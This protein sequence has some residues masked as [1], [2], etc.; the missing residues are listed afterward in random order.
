MIDLDGTA[1]KKRL[2]AN[3]IL[4]VSLAVAKAA[5]EATG[6]PLYRTSAAPTRA[7]CRCPCMNMINGGAHADNNLDLQEFMLVPYGFST[8]AEALRAGV[9][10]FHHLK[11]C[12][13]RRAS[14][15][16]SATRAASRP[17]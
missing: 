13:R 4:A 6:Q 3:A 9:E 10:S 8:F 1:T 5:A 17:T 2:G 15:R 16:P 7:R 12:S 11:E 14:A